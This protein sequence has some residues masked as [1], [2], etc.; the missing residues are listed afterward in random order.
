MK[1]FPI[2]VVALGAG[3]QSGEDEDLSFM[4]LPREMH[5]FDLGHMPTSEEARGRDE[6]RGVLTWAQQAAAAYSPGGGT[7]AM[8]VTQLDDPN[9]ELLDQ[10][11][12]EGEIAIS[13]HRPERV[14]IQESVFAGVWRLQYA[15]ESGRVL[16]D[17]VEVGPIPAVVVE[18]ARAVA[19]SPVRVDDIPP[20]AANSAPVLAEIAHHV[21]TR[22]PGEAAH[23]INLTLLPF[24]DA[25]VKHISSV[26]S[27]GSVLM[28]SRGYG[29]CRITSSVVRDTWWVQYFNS[30][31]QP[32]L[33]TLEIT[34]VPDVALAAHQDL[35]D[36][37]E[38]LVEALRW[39]TDG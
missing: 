15:D 29:N 22:A 39:L 4:P 31:D 21:A 28:L 27:G 34:D 37:A 18:S 14:R 17:V 7:T 24:A 25:D 5:T 16:R 35:A 1:P 13:I 38:R 26:V 23:V 10:V 19:T 9:R 33:D 12:G 2:P 30:M 36:T 6:A 32:L 11:I 3:S 8:D 20:E